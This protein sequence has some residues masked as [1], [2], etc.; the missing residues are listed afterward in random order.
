MIYFKQL[1]YSQILFGKL[2]RWSNWDSVAFY[3]PLSEGASW[4]ANV[5]LKRGSFQNLGFTV[6]PEPRSVFHPLQNV[7]LLGFILNS[8][9]VTIALPDE[10]KRQL[11]SFCSNILLATTNNICTIASILGKIFSSFPAA[12]FGRLHYRGLERCKRAALCKLQCQ[13]IS[14][15]WD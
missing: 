3:R 13:N 6:H 14:H 9:T 15:R 7:E 12:E 1:D 4:G 8:V 10:K 5:C 11:K 2:L